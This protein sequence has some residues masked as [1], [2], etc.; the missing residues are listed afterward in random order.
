MIDWLTDCLSVCLTEEEEKRA[1]KRE[2]GRRW[3]RRV[4]IVRWL[5]EG[6][7]IEREMSQLSPSNTLDQDACTLPVN[8]IEEASFLSAIYSVTSLICQSSLTLLLANE[9]SSTPVGFSITSADFSFIFCKQTAQKTKI[10]ARLERQYN[11]LNTRTISSDHFT[12]K[13]LH[14]QN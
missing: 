3:D 2:R 9:Y 14:K 4:E 10:L 7:E 6:R 8:C 13:K 12:I 11:L 1:W 5:V